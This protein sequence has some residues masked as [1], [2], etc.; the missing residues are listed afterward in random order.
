M[1][2]APPLFL[3]CLPACQHMPDHKAALAQEAAERRGP[4]GGAACARKRHVRLG[5]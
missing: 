3:F 1:R 2:H 4:V 5:G